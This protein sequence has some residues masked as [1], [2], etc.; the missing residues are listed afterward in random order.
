VSETRTI[1]KERSGLPI[2]TLDLRV[3]SGPDRGLAF[4]SE[5]DRIAIGSAEGN[6]VR[7]S[8]PTV[9]RFHLALSR[10]GDRIA[11]QDLGST[12]GTRIGPVSIQ[13]AQV[14]VRPEVV[15]ELGNTAIELR[16]GAVVMVDR[17]PSEFFGFVTRAPI[18]R[19]LLASVERVGK[20]EVAVLVLGESGTGKGR[21]AEGLHRASDRSEG[22]FEVVDCAAIPPTLFASALFGHER[23]AFTGA[24]E[25]HTGAFERARGGTLFLDEVGELPPEMQSM[26]LGALERRRARPLGSEREIEI[27]ARVV[28]ASSRD[29]RSAVNSG[30][31]RLDLFYRLAVVAFDVPPLRERRDDIAAIAETFLEEAGF[32]GTLDDVFAGPDMDRLMRH[33][34]PGNVRELRNVVLGTL[35]LGHAPELGQRPIAGTRGELRPYR[36]ARRA[37]LDEFERGYL[38]DLLERAGGNVREAARRAKMDRNY[39]SELLRRHGLRR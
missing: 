3:T 27:D 28:S 5:H 32:D 34:W 12:N 14:G 13:N 35:A 17:G 22:P 33:D 31:F 21:I 4:S 26:L 8:D 7:L 38:A 15:L 37:V 16:D 19:R 30:A 23:G 25:R 39:L 6:D 10:R 29:L 9:S 20:S 2:R 24:A 36:Q 1:P 18:M 11:V